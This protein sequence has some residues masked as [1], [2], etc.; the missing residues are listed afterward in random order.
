MIKDKNISESDIERELNNG[1]AGADQQRAAELERLQ[2]VRKAKANSL[3]RE[4]ARLSNKLGA[5]HPRIVALN[6]KI[7]INQG[8]IGD[9]VV[10]AERAKTK[11]PDVDNKSWAAHGYVRDR[12]FN[13]VPN[14]T[15]ALYDRSKHWIKGLGYACTQK[16][17]YFRLESRSSLIGEKRQVYLHVVDHQG[18]HLYI[19]KNPLTPTYGMVDYREIILSGEAPVC[20]PPDQGEGEPPPISDTWIV[21]GRVTDKQGRGVAGVTVSLFDKDFIF[22]DRLGD[23]RTDADGNYSITYFTEDFRDII[24]R[25]PDIYLMILSEEGE[26][27]HTTRRALKYEA[28]RIETVDIKIGERE[29][30]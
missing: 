28:G 6:T 25:R 24:E 29:R 21:R 14:L 27:L 16:N 26:K 30:T 20:V 9:L 7:K 2:V 5:T 17:G 23:T 19:D 13:G 11:I 22:D 18:A 1:I 3:Q 4:Q 12:K 10:E 8:L 15:V